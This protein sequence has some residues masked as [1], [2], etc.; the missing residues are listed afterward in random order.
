LRSL[1]PDKLVQNSLG[2]VYCAP[3][4]LK[5]FEPEEENQMQWS[6]MC[7]NALGYQ[8]LFEKLERAPKSEA[9]QLDNF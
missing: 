8:M 9:E 3:E 6:K 4:E 1:S 2:V 5:K 7:T